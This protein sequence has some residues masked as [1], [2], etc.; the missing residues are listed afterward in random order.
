MN[1]R[2]TKD[3]ASNRLYHVT[4]VLRLAAY[5]AE[6][7]KTLTAL[8]D[9]STLWPDAPMLGYIRNHAAGWRQFE[10]MDCSSGAVLGQLA[11]ELEGIHEVLAK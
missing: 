8:V 10:E 7:R 2:M 1:T 11:H 6:A 9:A 4:N 3:E 5:A